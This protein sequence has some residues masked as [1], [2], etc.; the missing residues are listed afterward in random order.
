MSWVVYLY[1]MLLLLS[2][3]VMLIGFLMNI[4]LNKNKSDFTKMLLLMAFV[5][6]V[7]I[8]IYLL[9]LKLILDK[10]WNLFYVF[11]DTT[12]VV[13]NIVI[14]HFTFLSKKRGGDFEKLILS[15]FGLTFI[16]DSIIIFL[17]SF[18]ETENN[19]LDVHSGGFWW[20]TA[21]LCF[22]LLFGTI[23]PAVRSYLLYRFNKKETLSLLIILSLN[24]INNL[25]G[26]Y[27]LT[28]QFSAHYFGIFLNLI[29]NLSFS[30]YLGYYLVKEYFMRKKESVFSNTIENTPIY[31]WDEFKKHLGNWKEARS[32]LM[33]H[34]P[35]IV[36]DVERRPLTDL[37]KMHLCLRRLKVSSKDAAEALNV[38]N[39]TVETQRYRINKKMPSN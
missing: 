24:L 28:T 15:L 14:G 27:S 21:F 18:F 34:T 30:Y 19:M 38:S 1:K 17:I 7:S 20:I 8:S 35:E 3:T 11:L 13:L 2:A 22:L 9:N 23:L 37:E 10:N 31:S 6:V 39:R 4:L 12:I 33:N 16:A 5:N 36:T 29:T 25:A 32:Y 26:F